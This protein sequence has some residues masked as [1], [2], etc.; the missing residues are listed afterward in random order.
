MPEEYR[1]GM[2]A[3]SALTIAFGVAVMAW[4]SAT[5]NVVAFLLGALLVAFGL[6]L[7]WSGRQISRLAS[8]A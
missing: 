3:R 4:P 6:A 8:V 5:V 1:S 2:L 7:L